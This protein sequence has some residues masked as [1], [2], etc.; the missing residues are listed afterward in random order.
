MILDPAD[1]SHQ[2]VYKLL[3]GS[4][5]PRPIAFVSTLS[6]RGE[7]NLAP[8]SFFNVVCSSPAAVSFSVMRRGDTAQKKDTLLN[9]E[10]T[11]EFVVNVVTEAIAAQVNQASADYPRGVDEFVEAGFTPRPSLVVAPPGVAESPVSMECRL[12]QIVHL[13]DGPGAGSLV[14]GRVERFHVSDEVYDR[15]RIDP[16]KLQAVGRMAGAAYTRTQDT[17]DLIRPTLARVTPG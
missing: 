16:A 14:I 8:F 7:R 5:V 15:G 2:E 10:E 11:R 9:I 3:N 4:V 1:L 6:A 13:G 12:I 17:F